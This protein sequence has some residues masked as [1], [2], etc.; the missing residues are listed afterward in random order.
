MSIQAFEDLLHRNLSEED[1]QKEIHAIM[2]P[3]S[4]KE[5]LELT[6]VLAQR[7][8]SQIKA[9]CNG[10]AEAHALKG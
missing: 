2:A 3:L 6:V 9:W 10:I 7:L 8:E 5:K 4:F 1:L